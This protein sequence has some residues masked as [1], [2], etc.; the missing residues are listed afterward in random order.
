MKFFIAITSLMFMLSGCQT[1]TYS[2]PAETSSQGQ[3]STPNSSSSITATDK[4]APPAT[5]PQKITFSGVVSKGPLSGAKVSVMPI[6]NGVVGNVIA[7]ATTDVTG[8]YQITLP[9]E[10]SGRAIQV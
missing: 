4:S 5:P 1:E 9:A 6:Q 10:F 3:G 7:T 2:T 8:Q